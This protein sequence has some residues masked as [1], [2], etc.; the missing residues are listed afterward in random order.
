MRP[1]VKLAGGRGEKPDDWGDGPLGEQARPALECAQLETPLQFA[2]RFDN[3]HVL[4]TPDQGSVTIGVARSVSALLSAISGNPK[5]PGADPHVPTRSTADRPVR[6]S[7][8]RFPC[9]L[10]HCVLK[11]AP[12]NTWQRWAAYRIILESDHVCMDV[13]PLM[14]R[15]DGASD[16]RGSPATQHGSQSQSNDKVPTRCRLASVGQVQIFPGTSSAASFDCCL[17]GTQLN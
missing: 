14:S 1:P 3:Q 9:L 13:S 17:E 4:C 15:S 6:Q 16:S 12:T 8:A 10:A 2:P 7:L 5:S 11:P